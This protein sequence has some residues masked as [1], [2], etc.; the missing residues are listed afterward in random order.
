[1]WTIKSFIFLR[2]LYIAS[3]I[4]IPSDISNSYLYNVDWTCTIIWPSIA[5]HVYVSSCIFFYCFR[6][7][8]NYLETFTRWQQT[9]LTC[10]MCKGLGRLA[11]EFSETFLTR[12]AEFSRGSVEVQSI[13]DTDR[14]PTT[15][16]RWCL[17][18]T[19]ERSVNIRCCDGI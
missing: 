1:M 4:N 18:D 9:E 19:R 16:G 5:T 12:F 7:S 8:C 14:G 3:I 6:K 15:G 17:R 2:A 11:R 13:F 10:L